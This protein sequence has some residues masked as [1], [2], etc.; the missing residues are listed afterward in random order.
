VREWGSGGGGWA[1]I[2]SCAIG[3]GWALNRGGVYSLFSSGLL[4][5]SRFEDSPRNYPGPP[6]TPP[7]GLTARPSSPPAAA[8]SRPQHP[9]IPRRSPVPLHR[10]S[11]HCL[12][13]IHFTFL[14]TP[15]SSILLERETYLY[16]QKRT[17]GYI[18]FVSYLSSK[19]C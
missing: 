15:L 2:R 5:F 9:S 8:P 17:Q 13:T 18:I 1:F 10:D 16:P 19:D 4:F 11:T 7:I 3:W 12:S 14:L 6:I